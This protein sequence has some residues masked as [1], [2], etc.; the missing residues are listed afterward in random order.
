MI[1]AL[2]ISVSGIQKEEVGETKS[3]TT[4]QLHIFTVV[5]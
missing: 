2:L 1:K 4:E 3:N 5:M